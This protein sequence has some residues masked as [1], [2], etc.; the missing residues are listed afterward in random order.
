MKLFVPEII[1]GSGFIV[2][3]VLNCSPK[4]SLRSTCSRSS[5]SQPHFFNFLPGNGFFMSVHCSKDA[6]CNLE[7]EPLNFVRGRIDSTFSTRCKR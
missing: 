5:H 6:T 1:A 7:R 3:I 4:V 2:Y